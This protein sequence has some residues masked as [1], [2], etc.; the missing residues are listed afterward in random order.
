MEAKNG[1]TGGDVRPP[2]EEQWDARLAR[3]PV[4][5]CPGTISKSAADPGKDPSLDGWQLMKHVGFCRYHR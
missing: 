5:R 3:F 4:A 2:V 1:G